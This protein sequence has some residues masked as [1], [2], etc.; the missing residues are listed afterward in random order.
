M[1]EFR[2]N[3]GTIDKR[4]VLRQHP[5]F[6][7]V[8]SA[9][10]D[11]ILAYARSK[12]VE[13][14]ETIFARLDPGNALFAISSGTVKITNHSADGKDLVLNLLNAGEI[15]GEVAF[16]DGR[17]RTANAVALTRTE[18]LVIDRRDFIPFL[19]DEPAVALRLI[20]VLC[21]RIRQTS[22]QV[23]DVLFLDL[24]KRLAKTLLQLSGHETSSRPGRKVALTQRELG[25]II[26]MSRE[27][28]N[29]QLREWEQQ[30]WV[31]L[32][33]GGITV[34]AADELSE[35]GQS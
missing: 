8:N 32:E 18:L 31:R 15:F 24:P 12:T 13:A 6:A 17:S 5:L 35:I 25:E 22:E 1:K 29:K 14:G 33:R 26:G 10:I 2:E 21:S 34:L 28:T 4:S 27:S 19:K 3:R 11:R 20:E 23:E 9:A 30:N 7:E 16:L